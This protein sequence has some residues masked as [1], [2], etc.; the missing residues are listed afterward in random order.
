MIF[1]N[2]GRAPNG[3]PTVSGNQ[4]FEHVCACPQEKR[5]GEIKRKVVWQIKMQK[6]SGKNSDKNRLAKNV[7]RGKE[8]GKIG[9]D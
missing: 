9:K 7:N 2:A 4:I 1:S 5:E 6:L 3:E 8:R